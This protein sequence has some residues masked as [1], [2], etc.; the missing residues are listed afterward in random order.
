M[1]SYKTIKD[2][3]LNT[4]TYDNGFCHWYPPVN[5]ISNTFR[6]AWNYQCDSECSW[7]PRL[8]KPAWVVEKDIELPLLSTTGKTRAS[9]QDV[10]KTLLPKT[11]VYF[12]P[13]ISTATPNRKWPRQLILISSLMTQMR[14]WDL[15]VD[16]LLFY[17]NAVD[18]GLLYSCYCQ[19]PASGVDVGSRVST[20]ANTLCHILEISLYPK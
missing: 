19:D 5:L 14:H 13:Q 9:D 11:N 18:H 7:G 6:M 15:H 4:V 17:G 12:R 10:V 16:N 8:R 2:T 1:K 20:V 3:F